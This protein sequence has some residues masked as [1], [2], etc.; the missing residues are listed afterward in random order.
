M[1]TGQGRGS[2]WTC[3]LLGYATP[4]VAGGRVRFR[5]GQYTPTKPKPDDSR[6]EARTE[7]GLTSRG[8]HQA[9]GAFAM[10]APA[11]RSGAST[12]GGIEKLSARSASQWLPT[13]CRSQLA[14]PKTQMTP[15]DSVSWVG[16]M[17]TEYDQRAKRLSPLGTERVGGDYLLSHRVTPAVPSAQ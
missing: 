15:W 6:V 14:D 17:P 2:R 4:I 9:Q 11:A 13:H 7:R 5:L 1:T 8:S 3:A 16:G 12:A 10:G